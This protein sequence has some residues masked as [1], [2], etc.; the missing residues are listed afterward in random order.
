MDFKREIHCPIHRQPL[1]NSE[2]AGLMITFA[3]F[4]IGYL[5]RP[6]GGIVFG[7]FGDRVGRK[8]TFTV[9]ILMMAFATLGLGLVPSYSVMGMLAP[10]LIISLRIIQGL[11][12]GGETPGAITY[13]SES[14]TQQKG[15]A[16]GI[17]FCALN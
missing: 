12:I 2:I 11:S 8:E 14:F 4:A 16:C 5:V 15:L 3:T 6:L 1:C 17:I 13:V 10:V 9:S 7:H